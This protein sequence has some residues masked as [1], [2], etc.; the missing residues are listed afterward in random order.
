MGGESSHL[1]I[2]ESKALGSKYG[3]FQSN[4][5][6]RNQHFMLITES[7]GCALSH[8]TGG[9]QQNRARDSRDRRAH[10][11][12]A[13]RGVAGLEEAAADRLHRGS[14]PRW[15][16][17]APELVKPCPALAFPPKTTGSLL[18]AKQAFLYTRRLAIAANSLAAK[19]VNNNNKRSVLVDNI[20]YSE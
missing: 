9:A 7:R 2:K 1:W 3:K 6:K 19:Q 14:A 20:C 8:L 5:K 4:W 15:P 11:Q 12:H 18:R 10:E 13:D 16:R 17:P